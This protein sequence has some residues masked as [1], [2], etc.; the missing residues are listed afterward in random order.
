[1]TIPGV[2]QYLSH[3]VFHVP[4]L[5]FTSSLSFVIKSS[6]MNGIRVDGK[7]IEITSLRNITLSGTMYSTFALS[8]TAGRHIVEHLNDAPFGLWVYGRRTHDSYGYPAGMRL[9]TI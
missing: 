8:V 2:D 4:D 9:S 7:A 3:Y 6:E 5:N 1:M